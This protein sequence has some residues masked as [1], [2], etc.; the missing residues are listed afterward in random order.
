M[1]VES[2]RHVPLFESL[3]ND[4]AHEL[5]DL[6]ESLDCKAGAVLFRTGDE[7]DAMY[8]I[9]DGKVRICMQTKDG[10]DVTLTELG[11]G[12]FFG[13]MALI[14]GKPRSADARVA[15]HA[16]LA[17]LSRDHFLSF[18]RSNPNVALEMLTA[19]ANRLRHT[20]ELLRYTATRNLNAEEAAQLTLSDR[21]ADLIAEFGGSW[22]FIIAAV[23]FFNVWV[24]INSFQI[25]RF[26][27]FP[28]L[29]LSTVVNMLAVLQAPI[30]LMSQNRQSHKDRLRAE[31]DYQVNLKN[32]LALNEILKRLKTLERNYHEPESDQYDVRKMQ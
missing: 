3:D 32:E 26:D 24:L 8:L 12:D 9:E 17:V 16:R 19:L 6:L 29:L 2:L 15:E 11:R 13:E 20:D 18:M 7:G 5:C 1:N 10:T 22:K 4:A 27:A 28:F 23:L 21:A 31:I 25:S 30:I 14:D